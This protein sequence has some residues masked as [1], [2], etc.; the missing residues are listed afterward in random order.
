MRFADVYQT[1]LLREAL[2][3]RSLRTQ[4]RAAEVVEWLGKALATP[5]AS[6]IELAT[7]APTGFWIGLPAEVTKSAILTLTKKSNTL[8]CARKL[9]EVLP[10]S[11]S[12]EEAYATCWRGALCY[13][14]AGWKEE[15]HRALE[16]EPN[17]P[18]GLVRH[19]HI[20]GMLLGTDKKGNA[21]FER[22]QRAYLHEREELTRQ[23]VGEALS[24]STIK[25]GNG[26]V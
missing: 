19:H 14:V 16:G 11:R 17:F 23:R 22:L 26:N 2:A 7:S 25:V 24:V 15:A 3:D 1:L 4:I 10:R 6:L 5:V 12:P 13:A 21:A 8:W 18:A 20:L 9:L